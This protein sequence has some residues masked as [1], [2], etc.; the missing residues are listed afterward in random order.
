MLVVLLFCL[1]TLH[2]YEGAAEHNFDLVLEAE[3]LDSPIGVATA[4]ALFVVDTNNNRVLRFNDRS[5]LTEDSNPDFAFGQN[6]TSA[7]FN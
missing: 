7:T 6:S 1:C 4:D 5:N 3:F 2:S